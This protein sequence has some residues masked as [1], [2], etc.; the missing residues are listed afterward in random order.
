MKRGTEVHAS[1]TAFPNSSCRILRTP[2]AEHHLSLWLKPCLLF[3]TILPFVGRNNARVLVSQTAMFM[4]L[5][6]L[7]M[8]PYE[9]YPW[10]GPGHKAQS[11]APESPSKLKEPTSPRIV[12]GKQHRKHTWIRPIVL[13][14]HSFINIPITLLSLVHRP[15]LPRTPLHEGL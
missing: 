12:T 9:G 13:S 8:P 5:L 14:I 2:R 3:A 15:N 10:T 4:L 1:V 6:W 11:V 7:I